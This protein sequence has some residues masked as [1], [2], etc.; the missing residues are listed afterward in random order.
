MKSDRKPVD[1]DNMSSPNP[2]YG[3]LAVLEA[4]RRFL[5]SGKRVAR[6]PKSDS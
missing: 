5:R 1:G 3:G 2:R 6:K 4:A